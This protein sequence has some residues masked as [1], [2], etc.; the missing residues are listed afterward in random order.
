[1]LM[2]LWDD[3]TM[4]T[5]FGCRVCGAAMRFLVVERD[6]AGNVSPAALAE[7]WASHCDD[8]HRAGADP[9]FEEDDA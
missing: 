9:C 1:M 3:G 8:R 4:D 2:E 6:D 5:V 7:A